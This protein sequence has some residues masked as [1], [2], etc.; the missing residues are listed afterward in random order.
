L[1]VILLIRPVRILAL[2]LG[3]LLVIGVLI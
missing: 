2:W 1:A 3:N